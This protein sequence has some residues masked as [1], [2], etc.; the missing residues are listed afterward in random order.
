MSLW[1][2]KKK[3]QKERKNYWLNKPR[4]ELGTIQGQSYQVISGLEQGD[5]IAVTRILDL[6]DGTSIT[7]ESIK[8]EQTISK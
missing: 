2:N 7:E 3:L 6:K 5:K 1:L 8:S 4:L